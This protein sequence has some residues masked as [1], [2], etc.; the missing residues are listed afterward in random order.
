M[1]GG[2]PSSPAGRVVE[3]VGGWPSGVIARGE[4]M[5]DVATMMADSARILEVIAEATL[6]GQDGRAI[7]E[8][9]GSIGAF[10]LELQLASGAYE[11]VGRVL[12][13]YGDVL[14]Q[15]KPRI[16]RQAEECDELWR[17]YAVLPGDRAGNTDPGIAGVGPGGAL[18]AVTPESQQ[19]AEDNQAKRQAY[20]AWEEA[21][22][23]LDRS[24]EVWRQGYDDAVDGFTD[25]MAGT[26]E[27]GAWSSI[28]DLI[29]GQAR[30]SDEV[31]PY[32]MGKDLPASAEGMA[33]LWS[34]LSV[35]D[36]AA[37]AERYPN[38]GNR[39]GIP[40]AERDLLNRT[41]LDE[42]TAG[43]EQQIADLQERLDEMVGPAAQGERV[44]LMAQVEELQAQLD[45]YASVEK[46]LAGDERFL[47]R[48]GFRGG[49]VIGLFTSASFNTSQIGSTPNRSRC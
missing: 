45:G 20:Q 47:N 10:P 9:Q 31:R 40:A 37:L 25:E 22:R 24:Y 11:Q 26:V 44:S 2:M 39:G 23:G 16:E 14:N 46:G 29:T 41:F 28:I 34:R 17:A 18:R 48:P 13:S 3:R 36:K 42:T 1:T 5:R 7:R 21:A 43:A 38:L 19:A 30:V 49:S 15:V 35:A 12:V 4:E 32:L 27:V 8:L 6:A 33:D